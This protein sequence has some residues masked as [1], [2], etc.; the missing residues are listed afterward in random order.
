MLAR[1][2]GDLPQPGE[3]LM[4]SPN[5]GRFAYQITT[6]EVRKANLLILTVSRESPDRLP[7]CILV[8]QWRWERA[9]KTSSRERGNRPHLA[10]NQDARSVT[11]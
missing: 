4:S 1:W 5:R 8:H 7:A 6:V 10:M 9:K 11:S 2:S 3:Y